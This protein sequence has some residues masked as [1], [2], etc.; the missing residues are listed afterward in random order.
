MDLEE[1]VSESIK[2]IIRGLETTSKELSNKRIGLYSE[3]DA[4]RRHIEFDVAVSAS[5]KS[6]NSKSMGGKIKVWEIFNVGADSKKVLENA[7]STVSR[8]KFGVRIK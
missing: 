5:D 8:I 1:F 6:G 2:G 4:N 3:G 7:N